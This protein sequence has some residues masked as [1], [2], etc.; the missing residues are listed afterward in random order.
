MNIIDIQDQ[1]KNFSEDQLINE[2]QM[3][4]G[5]APQFLVLSEIQRRKRMRDDFAKRQAAQ[6]PTVAEEAI[7]AAGVPQSGIAGMSEAM[8]PKSTMVQNAVGSA[9]PEAMRSGG[10]MQFGNDIQKSISSQEVD[11][12]LD[13][14]ED[15]A[16]SRFG[17]DFDESPRFG[18]NIDQRI[19]PAIG[20]PFPIFS[21]MGADLPF[22]SPSRRMPVKG[23]P[24]PMPAVIPYEE[25]GLVDALFSKTDHGKKLSSNQFEVRKGKDGRR[26]VYKK[27]TNIFVGTAD[28]VLDEKYDGG[29]IRAQNGLPRDTLGMRLNNPG[30]IRP[31]AG[32]FGESGQDKGYAKF[33]SDA[34]GLRAIQRL[35]MT[36]GN[37]YGINTL[38][39]LANRY[40]PPS[41]NNPT[42]NYIEFL[43]QKTGIDPDE[44]INLAE[45]GAEII[46]AIIGFEQG[47]QPFSQEMI[48]TAINAAQFDDE[49]KIADALLPQELIDRG[50]TAS[51]LTQ[52]DQKAGLMAAMAATS[53]SSPTPQQDY[54]E[55]QLSDGPF[56]AEGR[57]RRQAPN[58][59]ETD[60][61]GSG[62]RNDPK[63]EAPDPN[64]PPVVLEPGDTTKGRNIA[65]TEDSRIEDAKAARKLAEDR[66]AEAANEATGNQQTGTDAE[67]KQKEQ[68][69]NYTKDTESVNTLEQ[70]IIDLMKSQKADRESDKW[71]AIAQAGLAIMSSDNPTLLGAI[72]EG[73]AAGLKAY[74]EAQDR[75]NEGVI[76][77]IN[78]RAKLAK[79]SDKDLTASNVISRLNTVSKMIASGVDQNGMPLDPEK[80]KQ[81]QMEELTLRRMV[82]LDKIAV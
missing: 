46:P 19:R 70:E 30:N 39:G 25:G 12:F 75:Y 10:L 76:D 77:L 45:R 62:G 43:S 69:F 60:P 72:G 9:M 38:R 64:R 55:S 44:P 22:E 13:E 68:E 26:M 24:V 28:K 67:N 53:G 14:V 81:Y 21:N 2:M 1:L 59:V 8:A 11:P 4:S 51:D 42:E 3:P 7:A 82:G 5:N 66:A 15:M 29:L 73:G 23:G 56:D 27:G 52:E 20:R 71:L 47:K 17:V 58:R 16:E 78:A 49:D 50:V 31:G 54:L 79:A 36:Y 18:L 63:R 33:V 37:Q 61:K 6:Q 57:R 35:L 74:R 32:F 41:D 65:R 48:N 34:A 80:L 40:A